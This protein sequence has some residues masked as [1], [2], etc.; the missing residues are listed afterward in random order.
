MQIEPHR[1]VLNH[2]F[3]GTMYAAAISLIEYQSRCVLVC[4]AKTICSSTKNHDTETPKWN[5]ISELVFLL[6]VECT[7]RVRSAGVVILSWSSWKRKPRCSQLP[8]FF[9]KE[10]QLILRFMQDEKA[11]PAAEGEI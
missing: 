7:W 2:R 11:K 1:E 9:M 10:I 8:C 4:A 3:L 6:S 5:L